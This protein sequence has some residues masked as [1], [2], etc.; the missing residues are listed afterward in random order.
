MRSLLQPVPL[1]FPTPA[2]VRARRA[3]RRFDQLVYQMIADRRRSAQD[4]GDLLSI[5][6]Q[7]RDADDGSRMTD[8]QVRDEVLTLFLAGH[9]TTAGA[10]S[11]TWYD[12]V[13]AALPTRLC[14]R[15]AGG[16]GDRGGRTSD[17]ARRH[18]D[19]AD[20]GRAS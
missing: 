9:E 17:R 10:L 14:A 6:L 3:I 20:L 15:A 4:R 11:W 7:A 13:H 5:L 1:W 16:E 18:R 19:H 12:G 2:N 8:Q